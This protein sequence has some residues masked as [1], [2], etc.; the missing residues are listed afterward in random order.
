[1]AEFNTLSEV[2]EAV[3][4]GKKVH[5]KNDGYVVGVDM[6]GQWYVAWMP[7]SRNPDYVGL[8]H[9]DGVNSEYDAQ[10]FYSHA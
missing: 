4:A 9:T 7:Q 3:K 1:M 6:L 2:Q 8:F 5:W 10:D